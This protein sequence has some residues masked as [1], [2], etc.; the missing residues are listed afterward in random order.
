MAKSMIQE[1]NTLKWEIESTQCPL[2]TKYPGTLNSRGVVQEHAKC[3][4]P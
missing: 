3:T 2:K 4:C 1:I